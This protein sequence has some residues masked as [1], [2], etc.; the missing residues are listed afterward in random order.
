MLHRLPLIRV[1]VERGRQRTP[2]PLNYFPMVA[3]RFNRISTNRSSPRSNCSASSSG[4]VT[5]TENGRPA[6]SA[7]SGIHDR[8]KEAAAG[9]RAFPIPRRAPERLTL[10]NWVC[11]SVIPSSSSIEFC[12]FLDRFLTRIFNVS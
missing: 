11:S 3:A 9:I 12:E 10:G 6:R 4:R 5:P 7:R 2:I 8:S 1:R